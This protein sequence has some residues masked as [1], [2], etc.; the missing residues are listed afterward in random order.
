MGLII[1]LQILDTFVKKIAENEKT[2]FEKKIH[3]TLN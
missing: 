2:P 1:P 3:K